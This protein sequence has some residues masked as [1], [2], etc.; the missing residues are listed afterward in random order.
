MSA[1]EVDLITFTDADYA[2][3]F[4]YQLTSTPTY[5][6]FTSCQLLM[7]VRKLAEDVEV[8]LSLTSTFSGI[9]PGSSGI[10]ISTGDD[11]KPSIFTIVIARA[12]LA[13]IPEGDYVQSLILVTPDGLHSDL[14]RG[15]FTNSVGP[16]R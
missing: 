11:G 10:D 6:D 4:R 9:A 3:A 8:F 5:Y 16:T 12:A 14:W 15:T 7:E 13:E 2:Q 1:A